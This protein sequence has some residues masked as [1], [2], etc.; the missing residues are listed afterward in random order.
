[1]AGTITS[2]LTAGLIDAADVITGWLTLGTWA[3]AVAATADLLLQGA[4]ALNAQTG[5]VAAYPPATTG[6]YLAATASNLDLT[7]SERHLF[8]WLKSISWPA[9]EAKV[10][11]GMRVA[12]SSD[13][14]PTL[15]GT[16]PWNGP[17]N[18]NQWFVGGADTDA[19]SGW[20]C[21]VVDP[22]STADLTLG[23][24]AMNS[25][26]R[27]GVSVAAIKTV[28]GGAVK[29]QNIIWDKIAYGTGLTIKDGTAGTPVT[30]ADIYATDMATANCFGV[31]TQTGEIY[32]AAGKFLFGATDQTAITYFKDTSQV[33]VFQNFPVAA[34]FYEIKLQGAASYATTVQFGNYSAGL[35]SGGVTIRGTSLVARR[36]ITPVIV[37][38]G[39]GY[40]AGDTLTVSGGTFITAAKVKVITVSSGVIT[41]LRMDTAGS[42][43]V[44]PTG[45][46]TLTGGTGSSGT[47]TLT[48]TGGSIWTLT[49]SAANQTLNLYGCT[50]SQMMSA[51]LAS[52]TS[53]RGCTITNSGAVTSNS[54]TIDNCTFQDLA[55]ATPISAIYA[56]IIASAAQMAL[57]TNSKFISCNR[58]IKI[59]AAG[60]YTFSNLTF[61]GNAF[62]IENS[63]VATNYASLA[64]ANAVTTSLYSGSFV[65]VSQSFTGTGGTLSSASFALKKTGAPTGN[66]VV[67]LYAHSGVYGTS[68]IPTG[69]ALATSDNINVANLTTSYVT[70]NIQFSTAAQQYALVNATN[71]V[72]TIEYSGGSVGNTLDV[73]SNV[74]GYGG[75]YA[76]LTGTTWTAIAAN[77]AT[78]A[79]YVNANVIINA[80]NGANP[81]TFINTSN[82]STTIV[83]SVTVKV[84]VK[85][86]AGTAISGARVAVYKSSDMSELMNTTTDVNGIAQTTYNYLV[87]TAITIRVR[88][89]ST[90]ATKYFDNQSTGTITSS[91]FNSIVTLITD[92]IAT[93]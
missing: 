79:V 81:G 23:S 70:T 20:V 78:F 76:D 82:G 27:A 35:T 39:T 87:D 26:D 12:I 28:G 29:T 63:I 54:A 84:T 4:A 41:E 92:A 40:T 25:I 61:S 2:D 46:L 93:P 13:V 19:V 31:L 34:T 52:T 42:Y 38:G 18:S 68:S 69:A 74:G 49:A 91:G 16:T 8:F 22:N 32:Y 5:A 48:F 37:V 3:K 43:S 60:S 62:D 9:M 77:D 53:V 58:A 17:T 83:N 7:I 67:K 64:G 1:M 30:L 36:A 55:T 72:L 15:T 66:A 56:L 47:C 57:V 89:S 65:G 85:D 14:T 80:T 75:N 51:A 33:I 90:G 45:T 10:R 6:M 59:T 50:F 86:S 73:G 11:G 71:Y 21:Y 88:K 24:P 44:T